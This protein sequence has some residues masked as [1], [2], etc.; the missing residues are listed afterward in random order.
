MS[1]TTGYHP[2]C[3]RTATLAIIP[4]PNKT[5]RTSPRAYRPIALL[6]VLGKGL[7]QLL[8]RNISWLAITLEI[9]GKQQFSVL[10]LRS[11]VDLTICLTHDIEAAL[12]ANLKASFL[13]MDVKGAFDIVLPGRLV[14]RLRE[15]G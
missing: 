15:Q 11:V 4:K 3:F 13:M 9:V 14:Y 7:E 2:T 1:A 12:L 10:A 6:S 8:A 5:D